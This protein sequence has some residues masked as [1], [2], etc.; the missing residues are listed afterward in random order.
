MFGYDWPRLHAA[1]N[2]LPAA[3]L[4]AAVA[5]EIA[6]MITRRHTLRAAGFWTLLAGVLG[7]I[8]AVVAGLLA[9]NIIEHDD[10]A[11]AVMERHKTLGLMTLGVFALLAVWRVVRLNADRRGENIAWSLFGVAGV[12]LLVLT[13]QLG[14]SL[15]FSHALGVPSDTLKAVLARRG[16]MPMMMEHGDSPMPDSTRLARDSAKALHDRTPHGH[17]NPRRSQP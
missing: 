9:E 5:F 14:G 1:L 12:A 13:S 6:W 16:E 7:T 17:S 3:L 8:A 15:M 11:H 10:V 2:D 4:A